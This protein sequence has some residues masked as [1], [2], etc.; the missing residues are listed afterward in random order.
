M[1]QI[2]DKAICVA[3][4]KSTGNPKW[5]LPN[6]D[7]IKGSIYLV[8]SI[9]VDDRG[10]LGLKIAGYPV[11]MAVTKNQVAHKAERFRKIIPRTERLFKETLSKMVPPP[12]VN[13]R[14]TLNPNDPA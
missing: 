11:L 3:N 1:W 12:F 9:C 4:S 8:D 5:D 13:C 2:G 7:V 10:R 6:G 14:C